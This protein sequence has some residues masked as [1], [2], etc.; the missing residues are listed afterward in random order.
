MKKKISDMKERH[1]VRKI[2]SAV[3]SIKGPRKSKRSNK[4][5]TSKYADF[6]RRRRR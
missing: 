3:R 5:K 6:E 4:G 2:E 1:A